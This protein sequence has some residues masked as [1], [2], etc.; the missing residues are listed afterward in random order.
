MLRKLLPLTL[1]SIAMP[2]AAS[3]THP[4]AGVSDKET[5][6]PSGGVTQFHQGRGDVV[7]VLDRAGRWYRVAL[8]EGC[9]SSKGSIQTLSFDTD[10]VGGRID[11]FTR[12]T[13]K[14][15]VALNCMITSIR[16]SE[17]PPQVDSGSPVTLD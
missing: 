12:V 9:L 16:R 11:R 4:L 3:E 15:G 14:S 5:S 6:I 17:A 1:L 10:T 13:V 2:L 7:F 8:N